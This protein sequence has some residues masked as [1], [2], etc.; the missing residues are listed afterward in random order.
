MFCLLHFCGISY[1]FH[2]WQ[3]HQTRGVDKEQPLAVPYTVSKRESRNK[4]NAQCDV[5]V[6]GEMALHCHPQLCLSGL[7]NRAPVHG[8]GSKGL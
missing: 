7:D 2:V 5:F 4:C 1:A 3:R 8:L 6:S